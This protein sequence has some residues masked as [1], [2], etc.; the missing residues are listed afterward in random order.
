[1]DR[2]MGLSP[3]EVIDAGTILCPEA[4][5]VVGQLFVS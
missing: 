5:V 4:A 2:S 3:S 1:M